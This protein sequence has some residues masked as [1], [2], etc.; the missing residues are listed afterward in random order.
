[1]GDTSIRKN[2]SY[3]KRKMHGSVHFNKSLLLCFVDILNYTAR[4]IA[5]ACLLL[6]IKIAVARIIFMLLNVFL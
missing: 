6:I 5:H 3:I 2:Q 4:N 1:M